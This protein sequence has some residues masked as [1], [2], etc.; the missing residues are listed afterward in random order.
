LCP[1]GALLGIFS[2]LSPNK[3]KRDS[4]S[5]IDCELCTKACPSFIQ[6]DKVKTVISDE[7][8]SCMNC[9]DVCP[10]ADTLELKTMTPTKNIKVT[11]KAVAIGVVSIFLLITGAGMFTGNWQNNMTADEYLFHYERMY[12]YGHP[13]G[14]SAMKELNKKSLI[15]HK[16]KEVDQKK[17]DLDSR[18]NSGG[19]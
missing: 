10:V 9:V 2:I 11:K 15:N 16:Q 13:T 17:L 14:T 1:Y 12:S 6:V 18:K 3:I 7:C 5:C 8:T 19:E 4:A